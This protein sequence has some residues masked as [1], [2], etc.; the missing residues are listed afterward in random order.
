M[1]GDGSINGRINS[2]ESPSITFGFTQGLIHANYFKHISMIFL[3]VVSNI[4]CYDNII[5]LSASNSFFVEQFYRWYPNGVK[6]IPDLFNDDSFCLESLIYTIMDDGSKY[7]TTGQISI[8]LNNFPKSN[9]DD[10]KQC[11]LDK[12]NMPCELRYTGKDSIEGEKQF[13]LIFRTAAVDMFRND[14][15]LSNNIVDSMKYK[16]FNNYKI[17]NCQLIDR[18]ISKESIPFKGIINYF[19]RASFQA[20]KIEDT[21]DQRKCVFCKQNVYVSDF[22][23]HIHNHLS[24]YECKTC[25]LYYKSL[26]YLQKHQNGIEDCYL[27]IKKECNQCSYKYYSNHTCEINWRNNI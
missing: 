11:L 8:A 2:R 20:N 27:L 3:N 25:G 17:K 12:F 1:L 24:L 6:R 4:Y 15:V 22:N 18:K 14:L 16:F 26:E 23:R 13:D 19:T 5:F 9:L 21:N 10:F 7:S